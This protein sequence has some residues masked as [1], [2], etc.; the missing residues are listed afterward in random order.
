ML[1]ASC[2][3]TS[4]TIPSGSVSLGRIRSTAP[5]P[6][7]EVCLSRALRQELARRTGAASSAAPRLRLEVEL[8]SASV[9]PGMIGR[10]EQGLRVLEND[11]TVTL[12]ARL[13]SSSAGGELRWGPVAY[14]E[15]TEGLAGSTALGD[16]AADREA[17]A[18]SC[19]RLAREIVDDVTLYLWR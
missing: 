14:R 5:H 15:R 16:R 18:R 6:A 4:A 10:D 13:V 1:C 11:T 3:F 19:H 7:L 12:R 2:G 9:E 8:I 17:A